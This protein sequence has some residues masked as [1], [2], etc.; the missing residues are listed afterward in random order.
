MA[1][2][3]KS[4]N[5]ATFEEQELMKIFSLSFQIR[6]KLELSKCLDFGALYLGNRVGNTV[7]D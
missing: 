2:L 4:R 1:T 3:I 5:L 6:T 7:L